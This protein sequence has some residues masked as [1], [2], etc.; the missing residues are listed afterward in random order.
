MPKDWIDVA[1]TAVKIGL[2]SLITG[3]FT[4]LGVKFSGK[5]DRTQFK[6]EHK[7]KLLE[8]ISDDA[9]KYF[10]SWNLLIS[11]VSAA[12]KILPHNEPIE[13]YPAVNFKLIKLRDLE[14]RDSW[15]QKHAVIAKLRLLKAKEA[16]EKFRL[17]S[18][19]EKELRDALWFDKNYF[20]YSHIEVY[21]EKSKKAQKEFSEALAEYYGEI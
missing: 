5:S 16:S 6:L 18:N 12:A 10:N 17:C 4:Y 19:T 2:G 15:P 14:L 9:E 7:T 21:R 8:Q 3:F 13:K 11:P 1:D 20:N